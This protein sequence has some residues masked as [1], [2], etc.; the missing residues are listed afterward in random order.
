MPRFSALTL[1]SLLL[2][3]SLHA[4]SLRSKVEGLFKFGDGCDLPICLAVGEGH[5]NHYNSAAVQGQVNLINFLSDAIGVSATDF[6]ISAAS[7]GAIWGRSAQGLPVRTQTSSGPIFGER[8]QTLGKGRVMFGVNYSQFEFKTLRGQPMNDLSF[9]FVHE[10]E[11]GDPDFENDYMEVHTN[12]SVNLTAVT[13]F[14]TFGL[15]DRID[16]GVAVPLV[17]AAMDGSSVAN[18]ITFVNPSPHF[19]GTKTNPL[20]RAT[21]AGS[22]SASGI[23]DVSARLKV[24]LLKSDRVGFSILGDV[25]FPTGKEEDFLGAG[26]TSYRGLG[27]LSARLGAFS[28]HANVGYEHWSRGLRNDSFLATLG[29]DHL[30]APWATLAIDGISQWQIGENKTAFPAATIQT[31][32]IG[33][34]TTIRTIDPT[35]IPDQKD[36]ILLGSLGAKFSTGAG[37]VFVTNL[38]VPVMY[39]GLQPNLAWTVGMEYS[40]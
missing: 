37:V 7:S 34:A 9:K 11:P 27:I 26:E 2:T 6:P 3:F 4:Q 15:T 24:Q 33:T 13:A 5:G 14:A 22:G 35:N 36:H 10:R 38:I 18:I 30:L 1:L 21:A 12:L 39:G 29:F 25:K 28:P 19:F 16:L 23:G 8:S 17:R 40:F 32:R 31:L 20:Y